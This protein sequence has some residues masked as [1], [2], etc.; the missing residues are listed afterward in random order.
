MF[1]NFIPQ[2]QKNPRAV[3]QYTTNMYM[4]DASLWALHAVCNHGNSVAPGYAFR[5][6]LKGL[7]NLLLHG[8]QDFTAFVLTT[9]L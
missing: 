7:I 4:S 5:S 3:Y 2:V 8:N 9:S 6:S 1:Y